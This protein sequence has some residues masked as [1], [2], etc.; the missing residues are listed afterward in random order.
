MGT[1]DVRVT[2]TDEEHQEL[3]AEKAPATWK[4]AIRAGCEV[5]GE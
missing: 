3:K 5:V 4:E 2:L 1:K